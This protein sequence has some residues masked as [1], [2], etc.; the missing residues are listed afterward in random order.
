[1][2]SQGSGSV[3]LSFLEKA[4]E[5]IEEVRAKGLLQGSSGNPS[6]IV[7]TARERL[8][9]VRAKG[10]MAVVKEFRGSS[11]GILGE[12]GILGN[13]REKGV[14]AV[15]E[16]KFPRVKEIREKGLLGGVGPG[17]KSSSPPEGTEASTLLEEKEPH[18]KVAKAR[19]LL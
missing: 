10:A 15:L 8:E 14:L 13:V 2:E 1:M 7:E 16:E 11:G 5:R 6:G 3:K 18:I 9:E 12:G 19:L 17:S 4:R